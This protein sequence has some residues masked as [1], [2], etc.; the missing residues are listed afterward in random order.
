[1]RY[2][3]CGNFGHVRQTCPNRDQPAGPP[4]APAADAET[5]ERAT[6][7]DIAWAAGVSEPQP[8]EA[9]LVPG[10]LPAGCL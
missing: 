1:M 10:D 3:V 5:S 9:L 7:A 4:A 6:G 2:F 8:S